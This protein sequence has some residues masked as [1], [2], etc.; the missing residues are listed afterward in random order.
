MYRVDT[1]SN[2]E[3]R[4]IL[5]VVKRVE[6]VEKGQER[7]RHNASEWRHGRRGCRGN[8][9]RAVGKWRSRARGRQG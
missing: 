3:M 1:E 9:L 5:G 4:D 2:V 8:R 6:I 7:D